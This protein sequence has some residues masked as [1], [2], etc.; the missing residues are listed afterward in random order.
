MARGKRCDD[1]SH[2]SEL[3]ALIANAHRDTAK[4]PEP[5]SSRDFN[6]HAPK[7]KPPLQSA[8]ITILRDAFVPRKKQ[9]Q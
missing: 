1:W 6:P 3:L 7:R 8:P 4:R 5:Y 9:D 2:T